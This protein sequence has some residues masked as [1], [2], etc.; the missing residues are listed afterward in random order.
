[1]SKDFYATSI[2]HLL[3]E[4]KRIDVLII[5][6]IEISRQQ[7]PPD[8]N[9][10]KMYG[11]S[12]HEIDALI[13]E[14]IDTPDNNT[15][16]PY[17][18]NDQVVQ[19]LEKQK[20]DIV[21]RRSESITRNIPLRLERLRELYVL[22]PDEF[23][24]LLI[25][26]APE[27][28]NKYQ[29]FFA[30]LQDD[31]TQIRPSVDLILRLLQT[32]DRF[33]PAGKLK[34]YNL[35]A[36]KAPLI[37]R[38][39]VHLQEEAGRSG[40]PLLNRVVMMDERI[41]DYL[42]GSDI[43]ARE[44]DDCASCYAPQVKLDDLLVKDEF[45]ERLLS[46]MRNTDFK[47]ECVIFYLQGGYGAGKQAVAE[48]LCASAGRKLLTVDSSF[49]A[50]LRPNEFRAKILKLAR[51][52]ELQTAALL[53]NDFDLLIPGRQE[54]NDE[55]KGNS[56][57]QDEALLN[58]LMSILTRR[59]GLTFFAGNVVWE[60]KDLPGG[61]SFF[62]I[63]IPCPGTHERERLWK[64][65]ERE[66]PPFADDVD[67]HAISDRFL[68]SPGQVRDALDT[69]ASLSRWRNPQNT[70][71]EDQD[72]N[73]ACRLQS[74][75][76]LATLA[77]SIHPHYLWGDLIVEPGTEAILKE[78]R[79]R[80]T[81]RALVYEQ[82]G[83]DRKLAM[84]KGLHLLFSGPPGTGKTMAA[85]VLANEFQMSLYKID[86]SMVVSKYIGETE[87]NL[88]EIFHEGESSN[89]ILFFDE[90]DALFGK[91]SEVKDA[92]D[93]HANIEVGYLLQRMEQYSGIVILSTNFRRNMDDAFTRRLHYC[94]DFPLPGEEE[95]L[96]IWEKIWPEDTPL[97]P[98]LDMDFLAERL[99][100]SGG[101]IRNIALSAA[102]MAAEE[103]GHAQRNP[104]VSMA[105]LI[106]ATRREYQK[107]GQILKQATLNKQP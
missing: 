5:T 3:A 93:R 27:V 19:L 49:L 56:A 23:D 51:E 37:Q 85:D 77:Q 82:W 79:T 94:V 17:Q 76:R 40:Q 22:S 43:M 18:L 54:V 1:M 24:I 15:K 44:I 41:R 61:C 67:L 102:F 100:I 83:F 2:Q 75:R 7:L 9:M 12:D 13:R 68:F 92:H 91:R 71:I 86:L 66:Y 52:T 65:W 97:S 8:A 33:D 87:K 10:I 80:V 28:D 4:L 21:A 35:F 99:E 26:L 16:H 89:A 81:H 25:S 105:H 36:D 30:Y 90:A 48:C 98:A 31:K 60:P 6:E 59:H 69:A 70:I 62:R 95:R 72:L 88:G 107:M 47:Q 63:P 50:G 74:N 34:K 101:Y 104:Q 38:E 42:L 20:N 58:S 57:V 64:L 32:A 73:R 11:I 78:I 29:R 106:R 84:G 45:K 96:R 39:L 55:R 103:A 53:I 46:L 14:S